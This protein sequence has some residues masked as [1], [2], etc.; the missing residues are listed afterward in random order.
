MN[1]ISDPLRNA[2]PKV[3]ERSVIHSIDHVVTILREL[4]N[5]AYWAEHTLAAYMRE[6]P[7]G[8]F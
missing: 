5:P 4:R 8:E 2:I 1:Q 6:H 7:T 3:R